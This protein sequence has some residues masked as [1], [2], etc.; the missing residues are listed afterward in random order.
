MKKLFLSVVILGTAI[1]LCAQVPSSFK[2]Q[3]VLRDA[4][5]NVEVSKSVSIEIS[6]LQGS[7]TGNSV[8]AETHNVSTN[9]FGLINL[10]I[11]SKDLT[12]FSS[13]DWANGPFFIKISVDGVLL[14][15]SEL[16][17]VPFAMYAKTSG[18]SIPG[19]KGDKGE[20]GDTGE[21]GPQGNVGEKGDQGDPGIAFDDSQVLTDKTWTSSKINTELGNKADTTSLAKVAISGSYTDLSGKPTNITSF[22]NDAGYLTTY[23][24]TDP[25]FGSSAANGITSTNIANWNTAFGWGNHNLAGYLTSYTETD[26]IFGVSAAKGI[27]STNITNWNEAYTWGD[28]SQAGY[29]TSYT[30]TDP[31]WIADSSNYFTKLNLKTLGKAQIHFGNILNKPTTLAGYGITD[32]FNGDYHSLINTPA[33]YDSSWAAIKGKPTSIAGYGITDAFNGDYNSLINTPVL[34]DSSWLAIKG[35]PTTIAGYGITDGFQNGGESAGANRTLGNNDYYSLGLKTNNTTRILITNDGNVGIGKTPGYKVD[36]DGNVNATGFSIGG[37]AVGTS[38]D[39]YWN[40]S[41]SNIYRASD[42]V[43]I[44]TSSPSQKLT[45][46]GGHALFDPGYGP[47]WN[48]NTDFAYVRFISTNN[49][50][51]KLEI[52]TGDDGNEPITFSQNGTERMRIHSNGYV[53][54]GTNSPTKLFEAVSGSRSL[55]YDGSN[56]FVNNPETFSGFVRLGAAF[57]YPGVYSTGNL[58]LISASTS[59]DIVL[60]TDNP[61]TASNQRFIVKGNGNIGIGTDS[62]DG[63]IL[64][65]GEPYATVESNWPSKAKQGLLIGSDTD[66]AYFGLVDEGGNTDEA[67]IIFGDDAEDYFR[68]LFN[69]STP[70]LTELLRITS[71]GNMG[72]GTSTTNLFSWSSIEKVFSVKSTSTNGYGVIEIAGNDISGNGGALVAMGSGTTQFSEIR[73]EKNG[74]NGGNLQFRTKPDGGSLQMRMLINSDGNMGI[75]TTAPGGLLGLR[76]SDNW[77]DADANNLIFHDA[78]QNTK[79][80]TQIATQWTTNSANIYYSTGNVGISTTTPE[81]PL[82][83]NGQIHSKAGVSDNSFTRIPGDN[84]I[85]YSTSDG[86]G[87]LSAWIWRERWGGANFG[88]F[89]NNANDYIHF[90]GSSIARMSI[91]L[92]NG[93]VGIGTIAPGSLLDVNGGI[94]A[95]SGNNGYTFGAG[96]DTD[97]GMFSSSDGVIFFRTNGAERLT[98]NAGNVGIGTTSPGGLLGLRNSD[99]WIDADANNLIFHDVNTG[100][101]TLA[102]VAPW[103]ISGG[104][105]LYYNAGNVGINTT[106]LF[107]K[108]SITVP[109]NSNNDPIANGI[110]V[111]NLGNTD[112]N[113]DAIIGIHTADGGGDPIIGFYAGVATFGIGMDNTDDKLKIS[114]NWGDPGSSPLVTIQGNNYVGIGT[115]T[116]GGLLGLRNSDS[117]IDADASNLIFHDATQNT[118]TLSQIATQWTTSGSNIYYNSGNV[119]IGTTDPGTKAL[120][121]VGDAEVRNASWSP[122]DE[123]K[124]FLGPDDNVW[125]AHKH[126]TGLILQAVSTISTIFRNET[127]ENMRIDG[128]GNVGI[129]T[130]SPSYRLSVFGTAGSDNN[131]PIYIEGSSSFAFNSLLRLNSPNIGVGDRVLMH[132]GK[133]MSD[134][135]TGYLGLYFAGDASDDNRITIGFHSRDDLLTLKPTG[136]FGIGTTAPVSLLD[137]NGTAQLRGSA[138]GTGLYVNNSGYVGIGT[139]DNLHKFSLNVDLDNYAHGVSLQNGTTNYF[140]LGLDGGYNTAFWTFN[141]GNTWVKSM[142][143][144]R[145]G[146]LGIGTT[147]PGDMLEIANSGGNAVMRIH[148]PGTSEYKIGI[149]AGEDFLRIVN[150]TGGAPITSYTGGIIIS[151]SGYVGIGTTTPG[152]KLTVE[153]GSI[154]PAYGNSEDAGIF[155][156]TNIGGGANDAAWMRYYVRSGEYTTL[157]IGISDNP[158]DHIALMPSGGVG[159][160]TNEPTKKLDVNDNGIRIRNSSSPASNAD[161]YTGE[162]RW[163]GDFIYICTSGDGAGGATDTWKRAPLSTY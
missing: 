119:G 36:V 142:L 136:N 109:D 46:T 67:A 43:G 91:D 100:T 107:A 80:L 4:T 147:T 64:Q 128:I 88:I 111:N 108:L 132:F 57:G 72:I 6:I 145:N 90:V 39:S 59:N 103:L 26:P 35:K 78:T 68:I 110:Y 73:S 13:I 144:T 25:V 62:P 138:G 24:E 99:S 153:G 74:T 83:V 58:Y 160:G 54:I 19:P 2:Y 125:L 141:S 126:S 38:T 116:P 21:T 137:V 42:N 152:K 55:T 143:L 127:K 135:N 44:G 114:A 14:G 130:A 85:A 155:F 82:D 7:A 151:N 18:S 63:A 33:L 32:A 61:G 15:T 117:W 122:G 22:T 40:V 92:A 124:L 133:G 118:K 156:P 121:V 163:D 66:N 87:S 65:I 70:T 16:L 76:N 27:S 11:G 75:G 106:T 12:T 86:G 50:D 34:Y 47:Y 98:I 10:E 3:A 123:A 89:H 112:D 131:P 159:I 69:N 49:D 95:A 17:S 149:G 71:N 104:T 158:E 93:N 97:G 101:R 8:Y 154:R 161:G 53:G 146:N 9:A 48:A 77:I 23:T 60:S 134:R 148:R 29:L 20:K 52:G 162:I 31:V 81:F 113:D 28:H 1:T 41:G 30:E 56:L 115:T 139:K 96:G 79:T 37:I 94:K 105:N 140:S 51:S 5:G 84:E 157:E 120:K 150:S 45:I 129:G 102:Q